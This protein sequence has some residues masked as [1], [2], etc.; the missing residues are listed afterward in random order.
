[1]SDRDQQVR[2]AAQ[3]A[4]I[5]AQGEEIDALKERVKALQFLVDVANAAPITNIR[6]SGPVHS[7]GV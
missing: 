4:T 2:I 5:K 6:D 3:L 1:M 7:A